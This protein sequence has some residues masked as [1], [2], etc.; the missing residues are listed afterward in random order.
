[1]TSTSPGKVLRSDRLDADLNCLLKLQVWGRYGAGMGQWRLQVGNQM[2]LVPLAHTVIP[3][4][5]L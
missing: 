1:M 3:P 5:S 2:Y 4:T